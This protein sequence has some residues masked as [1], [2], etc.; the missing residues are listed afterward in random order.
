MTKNGSQQMT[1]APVM[2]ASVLAALRSRLD[3]MF[4]RLLVLEAAATAAAATDVI[5]LVI[6]L[7]LGFGNGAD[8]AA[9]PDVDCC[10]VMDGGSA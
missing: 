3:S 4:R 6:G 10:S 1:K 2:M 9:G 7:N 8:A 5:R